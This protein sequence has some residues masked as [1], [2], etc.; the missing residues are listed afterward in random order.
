M[1]VGSSG[2]VVLT[3]WDASP[4]LASQDGEHLSN[5]PSEEALFVGSRA[6][7]HSVTSL[8]EQSTVAG[9]GQDAEGF[10]EL[11]GDQEGNTEAEHACEDQ[12]GS[13]ESVRE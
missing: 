8:C 10:D 12:R 6:F 7:C 13:E 3:A 11:A 2:D 1:E 4:R 5:R 9:A